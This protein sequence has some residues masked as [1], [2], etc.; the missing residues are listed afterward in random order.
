MLTDTMSPRERGEG[1]ALRTER[2]ARRRLALP[3]TRAL[4][5]ALETC[6]PLRYA[7]D[8]AVRHFVRAERDSGQTLDAVLDVLRLVLR[9][10]VNAK[11]LP[12]RRDALR[13]AVVWF[14]VSEYHRAD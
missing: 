8:V 13:E 3:Q 6:D 7:F 10:Q 9:E 5:A 11:L 4:V 14:A 1:D 12:E 2:E